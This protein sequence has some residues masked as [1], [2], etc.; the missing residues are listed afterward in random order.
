MGSPVEV[1]PFAILWSVSKERNGRVA[2]NVVQLVHMSIAKWVSC[3]SELDNVR[4]NGVLHNW[5]ASLLGGP[6]RVRKLVSWA[7]PSPGVLRFNVDGRGKRQVRS[8]WD[9]RG[10]S[11]W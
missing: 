3:W 4:M 1:I 11:Q 5:E 2:E 10:A 7:A 6:P 9:W 8:G